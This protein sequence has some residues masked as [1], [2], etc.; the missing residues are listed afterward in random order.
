M[1]L[2]VVEHKGSLKQYLPCEKG[3]VNGKYLQ[4]K[5]VGGDR[6]QPPPRLT[7]DYFYINLLYGCIDST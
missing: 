7:Y 3:I 4:K 1:K 6:P 2:T 5:K